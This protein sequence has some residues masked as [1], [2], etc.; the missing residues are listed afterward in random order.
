[1]R[2]VA[3]RVATWDQAVVAYVLLT[4][5]FAAVLPY[6]VYALGLVLYL[7]H[8]PTVEDLAG[9]S[10]LWILSIGVLA[11]VVV[12]LLRPDRDEIDTNVRIILLVA[13]ISLL[14]VSILPWIWVAV[15]SLSVSK[16]EQFRT[17]EKIVSLAG[18][19]ASAVAIFLGYV[20]RKVAI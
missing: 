12:D 14:V 15:E 8:S 2:Q 18:A 6:L 3:E 4:V 7:D 13:S 10:Q 19:P 16:V 11:A 5:V 17:A 9:G 1:V 20:S